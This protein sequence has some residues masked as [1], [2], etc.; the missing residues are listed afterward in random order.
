MVCAT[1]PLFTSPGPSLPPVPPPVHA[2]HKRNK[3]LYA[4]LLDH[5]AS[6]KQAAEKVLAMR[7][8]DNLVRGRVGTGTASTRFLKARPDNP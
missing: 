6:V 3:E 1:I 7:R 8:R 2:G 5:T 4:R